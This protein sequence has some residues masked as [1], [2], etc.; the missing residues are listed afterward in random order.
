MA[1]RSGLSF[2]ASTQLTDTHDRLQTD[3][4]NATWVGEIQ[5]A[6][7]C[8]QKRIA[9]VL[10]WLLHSLGVCCAIVGDSAMYIAGKSSSQP[11]FL[12]I[13]IA[14]C[15]QNL[16]SDISVLLQIQYTEAFSLGSLVFFLEPLFFKPGEKIVY[17]VRYGEQTLPV[18]L[19][20]IN[21]LE[22][23][24]PRSNLDFV[25]FMW[26]T[27]A[28]YCTNYAILV[29]PSRTSCDKILYTRHYMAE[30]GS[31]GSR[32][33]STCIVD[34]RMFN[35]I[36]CSKPD[37]C[38]CIVCCKQ[39]LSLKTAASEIVFRFVFNINKFCF[40]QTTTFNQYVYA[41]QRGALIEQLVGFLQFPAM[42]KLKCIQFEDL[43]RGQYHEI[44]AS[45][46]YVENG[47]WLSTLEHEFQ[48]PDEFIGLVSVSKARYWC[49]HCERSLFIMPPRIPCQ[50][51]FY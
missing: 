38:T 32:G 35:Y 21:S 26:T 8:T 34:P 45:T 41:I 5:T 2:D 12:S 20:G 24:G 3:T 49:T 47:P 22:P 11:E 6:V 13:Y 36:G 25:H 50:D 4:Y 37:Q 16:S 30:N 31:G 14:Y 10:L 43:S 23:C 46:V 17:I 42:L 19:M 51:L 15:A 1:A 28:H 44:C 9:E 33:C 40:D 39:P 48:S 7:D 27:F 29:L 18:R